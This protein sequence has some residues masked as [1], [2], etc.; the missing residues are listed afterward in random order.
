MALLRHTV[1]LLPSLSLSF[2][3]PLLSRDFS[4]FFSFAS[5]FYAH[6]LSIFY[7]NP[8]SFFT[9]QFY[10]YSPLSHLLFRLISLIPI[11][12]FLFCLFITNPFPTPLHFLLFSFFFP[13]YMCFL[14]T[15][16]QYFLFFS[17]RI[18]PFCLS[19]S[20]YENLIFI[21]LVSS[22]SISPFSL[23]LSTIPSFSSYR[24]RSEPSFFGKA[25]SRVT[26]SPTRD[27]LIK[28]ATSGGQPVRHK[29]RLRVL[30]L[31]TTY[32]T[33]G[34]FK[35]ALFLTFDVSSIPFLF[36]FSSSSTDRILFALLYTIICE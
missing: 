10:F 8:L 30:T 5:I 28:M 32:T 7:F 23:S 34:A 36:L 2:S 6:L 20:L 15:F 4:F 19:L 27:P 25:F 12:I 13:S 16:A 24:G 1:F 35:E 14:L 17:L 22:A 18:L 31:T 29:E 3:F 11:S 26:P 9:C 21:S 33:H